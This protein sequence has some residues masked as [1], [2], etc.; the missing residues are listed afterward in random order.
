MHNKT[1]FVCVN[2]TFLKHL[3]ILA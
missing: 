3:S 2:P 1:L